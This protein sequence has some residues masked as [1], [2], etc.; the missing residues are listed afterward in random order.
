MISLAVVLCFGAGVKEQES[1]NECLHKYRKLSNEFNLIVGYA[2]LQNADLLSAEKARDKIILYPDEFDEFEE[3][4]VRLES[5]YFKSNDRRYFA[6]K[7]K[8]KI[9]EMELKVKECEKLKKKGKK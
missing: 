5:E 7:A 9:N 1:L 3:F 6:D 4:R 2:H 8:T